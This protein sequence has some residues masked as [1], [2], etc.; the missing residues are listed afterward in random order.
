[1]VEVGSRELKARLSYYLR[2]VEAGETIAIKIHHRIIG[3]LSQWPPLSEKKMTKA[4]E[5]NLKEMDR[6]IEK[7]K[8]EGFIVS[9]GRFRYIP[10]KP[11][12]MT[13]GPSST[14]ILRQ[15][16]DEE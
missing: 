4:E 7:L 1:M 9:G 13:P 2:L 11:V 12:H 5:K 16:R 14:E 6:K 10:N 8:K 3:F 15:M